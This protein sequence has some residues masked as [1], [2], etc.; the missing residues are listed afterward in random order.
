[1]GGRL[2]KTRGLGENLRKWATKGPQYAGKS[3][4]TSNPG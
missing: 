3:M 2:L 1:M 4:Q